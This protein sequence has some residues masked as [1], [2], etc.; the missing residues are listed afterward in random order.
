MSL[1]KSHNKRYQ[2]SRKKN[3]DHSILKLFKETLQ[4]GFFLL[5]LKLVLSILLKPL[6]GLVGCK[7][8]V[9]IDIELLQERV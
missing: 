9:G 4:H 5:F 6:Q 3:K 1:I 2:S 7:P 8:I